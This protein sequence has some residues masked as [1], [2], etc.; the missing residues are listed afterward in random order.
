MIEYPSAGLFRRL[1]Q[2]RWLCDW[3]PPFVLR[4]RQE[5]TAEEEDDDL[6]RGAGGDGG[7]AEEDE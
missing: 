3:C 4:L 1:F 5:V 6:E 7:A 2:F